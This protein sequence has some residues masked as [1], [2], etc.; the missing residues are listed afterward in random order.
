MLTTL[1]II[2]ALTSLGCGTLVMTT[3]R[4]SG[5]H[6]LAWVIG[7]GIGAAMMIAAIYMGG[8]A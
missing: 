3:S 2:G 8:L 5:L 1:F 7:G 4:F 6:E